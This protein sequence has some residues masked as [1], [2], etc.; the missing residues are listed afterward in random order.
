MKLLAKK[1]E[2]RPPSAKAVMEALEEIEEQAV[3]MGARE[4]EDQ[5]GRGTG[6]QDRP[7]K[8]AGTGGPSS[9]PPKPKGSR[10]KEHRILDGCRYQWPL[11]GARAE[12]WNYLP[13]VSLTLYSIY[14][15][16]Q[17][18]WLV[19]RALSIQ[20]LLLAIG[21]PILP[22]VSLWRFFKPYRPESIT[23]GTDTFRHDLGLPGG[24]HSGA[25][26]YYTDSPYQRVELRPWWRQL[27][28]LSL[29]VEISKDELGQVDIETDPL[30][31]LRLCYDFGVDRIEIGRYLQRREKEWLAE[32]IREWQMS[33][34]RFS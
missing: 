10:I 27:L 23:L 14:A 7:R 6:E 12:I 18:L 28:G 34:D 13:H 20:T 1:P 25:D 17:A 3:P 33:S 2:E 11:P 31:K 21:W 9:C 24:Y 19:P 16:I 29:V 26:N 22:L 30:K 5:P 15:A 8:E 4:T 32:V